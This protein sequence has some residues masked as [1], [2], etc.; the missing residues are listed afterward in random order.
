M[1]IS[2]GG[3]IL[4]TVTKRFGCMA[5]VDGRRTMTRSFRRS[6]VCNGR[7]DAQYSRRFP[8]LWLI[9][10]PEGDRFSNVHFSSLFKP[11]PLSQPV[12]R[13]EPSVLA[14]SIRGLIRTH[15]DRRGTYKWRD[16]G[17]RIPAALLLPGAS[18]RATDYRPIPQE[19]RLEPCGVDHVARTLYRGCGRQAVVGFELGVCQRRF[20]PDGNAACCRPGNAGICQSRPRSA[21]WT[22]DQCNAR[23]PRTGYDAMHPR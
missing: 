23:R 20:A 13:A 9:F 14:Q 8:V 16:P 1:R 3:Q 21:R 5:S 22:T 18:C 11:C 6:S 17:C 15:V 19:M 4:F 7:T 2:G 12:C 10:E